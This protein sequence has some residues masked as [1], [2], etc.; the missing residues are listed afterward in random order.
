VA[1]DDTIVVLDDGGKMAAF[2]ADPS[3]AAPP[4]PD[5]VPK[6]AKASKPPKTPKPKPADG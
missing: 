2:R 3:A 5:P 6:P 1:V 4:H